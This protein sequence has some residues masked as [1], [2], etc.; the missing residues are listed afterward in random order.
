MCSETHIYVDAYI[1]NKGRNQSRRSGIVIGFICFWKLEKPSGWAE[2]NF[3]Y[4][5]AAGFLQPNRAGELNMGG[6]ATQ[7][8]TVRS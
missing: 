6:R 8:L 3:S 7:R 5:T 1:P 2:G 4:N